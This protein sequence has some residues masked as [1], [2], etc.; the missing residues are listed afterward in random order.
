VILT[1]CKPLDKPDFESSYIYTHQ[2][3]QKA[4]KPTK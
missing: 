1:I 4:S 3:I 2:I